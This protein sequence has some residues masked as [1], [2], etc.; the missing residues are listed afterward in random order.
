MGKRENPVDRDLLISNIYQPEDEYH[1]MYI[2]QEKSINAIQP[3]HDLKTLDRLSYENNALNPCI[4]AMITNV[5]GTGFDLVRDA[6][7]ADKD[8][9]QNEDSNIKNMWDFFNEPWPGE[10]FITQRKQ[11][12]RDMHRTGNGYLEVI[13]NIAGDIVF[14]RHADSKMMRLL[15]LDDVRTEE[16]EIRRNGA[17]VKRKRLVRYRR[18]VQIV[19]GVQLRYFKEFGC[20]LDLDKYT[21]VWVKKGTRIHHTRRA[22]EIIHFIDIPDSRTPYGFP[23]WISQLPSILG[24]REAEEF[25]LEFFKN[26]GVPP[27][28]IILQGGALAHESRRAL[29][30][31]TG[32]KA[33][34]KN[35]VQIME[36]E[37]TGGSLDSPGV[38]RVTV[39]RFGCYSSDTEI[40]TE[41]GWML[42]SDWDG[43][44]VGSVDLDT[45]AL[46]FDDPVGGLQAYDYTGEMV[47]FP[48]AAHDIMVTPNH[49]IVRENWG[50]QWI[51]ERADVAEKR[52]RMKAMVAPAYVEAPIITEFS[53]GDMK[54]PSTS[55]LRFLGHFI[56]D[57][58]TSAYRDGKEHLIKL[59][60]KKARKV[61]A[62]HS[63][64]GDVKE[65]GVLGRTCKS[66]EGHTIFSL[67]NKEL[68]T[69]LRTCV[70]TY[71]INKRLPRQF[72]NLN[73]GQS[74]ILLQALFE[75]DAHWVNEG[76]RN[77]YVYSTISPQLADNVQELALRCGWRATLGDDGRGCFYVSVVPGKNFASL[78]NSKIKTLPSISKR[79]EY[80]GKVYCFEMP[81]HTIVTRRNGR[82][83]IHGNSDRS[84]DSMFEQYDEKC[85]MR[86]RKAFRL[87]PIFV[88]QSDSYS[89]ATA[90]ASYT[91]TEAQVFAPERHEFD[92]IMSVRL[93]PALGYTG[94]KMV[95]RPM[96][97]SDSTI[98]LTGTG[99]AADTGF[100][101]AKEIVDAVNETTG[102]TLQVSPEPQKVE[103]THPP[104][105]PQQP[106]QGSSEALTG[107]LNP[108][109]ITQEGQ[110]QDNSTDK[111]PT[112]TPVRHPEVTKSG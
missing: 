103:Y 46:H 91:V 36:M 50:G 6:P 45:G 76:G 31:K 101:P 97:I 4:E 102:L 61:K 26:G 49:N 7:G 38:A 99:I 15:K 73:S 60:V 82:V 10:S 75:G 32:G 2:G 85:E 53:I 41:N 65:A 44:A 108:S 47:H 94:Y 52:S 59:A 8:D 98:R 20:P 35:R 51:R 87:P 16:T 72:L 109:A 40:L 30:G 70:G 29:E 33:K 9:G 22:S 54:F 95:S 71:A 90:Y 112:S 3:T 107:T 39:E 105:P 86:V 89:F 74:Q 18:F 69:W 81:Y 12:R 67:H 66:A 17:L 43:S 1:N 79:V 83:S 96:T 106:P 63:W 11:V 27:V 93:I 111:K 21:G 19:N 80:S 25:N 62:F 13:R 110:H 55:F 48:G 42:F 28:L 58:S 24:S 88:G 37:P 92:E 100:V 104:I 5:D 14:T 78:S 84:A 68:R 34:D 57:G 56:A 77:S 23:R 64:F